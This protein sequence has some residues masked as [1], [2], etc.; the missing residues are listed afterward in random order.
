MKTAFTNYLPSNQDTNK[1]AVCQ[2]K[3]ILS[4]NCSCCGAVVCRNKCT[5][6]I[7]NEDISEKPWMSN[8]VGKNICLN[9]LPEYKTA[10][11]KYIR[12]IF[13][14][15]FVND[16]DTK[17]APEENEIEN[18]LN[19]QNQILQNENKSIQNI[20]NTKAMDQ[21][22]GGI[23]NDLYRHNNLKFTETGTLDSASI[24]AIVNSMEEL[25]NN[26]IMN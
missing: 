20:D 26:P 13:A 15:I 4:T 19:L 10:S 23:L 3:L 2:E 24:R 16:D 8:F 14:D 17:Y 21:F 11:D 12:K 22:I 6:L 25:I 7:K 5:Q 9:C 18:S 1:C